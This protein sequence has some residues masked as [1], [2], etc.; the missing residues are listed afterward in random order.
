MS[1]SLQP[2]GTPLGTPKKH[3][4][5]RYHTILMKFKTI[6]SL[7]SFSNVNAVSP[8]DLFT[9]LT[10]ITDSISTMTELS[11]FFVRHSLPQATT[12]SIS[13]HFSSSQ[14]APQFTERLQKM[15]TLHDELLEMIYQFSTISQDVA[16]DMK[17]ATQY[18]QATMVVGYMNFHIIAK[19]KIKI[20]KMEDLIRRINV[21]ATLLKDKFN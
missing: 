7:A 16:H 8:Q 13:N 21:Y 1:T 17:E 19:Y 5:D 12:T 2:F 10:I 9:I 18:T 20:C 14:P 6:P 4:F 15:M 11:E 3:V